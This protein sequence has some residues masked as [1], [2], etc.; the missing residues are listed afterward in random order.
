MTRRSL[1][2]TLLSSSWRGIEIPGWFR[3]RILPRNLACACKKAAAPEGRRPCVAASSEL[4]VHAQCV[5]RVLVEHL[6]HLF[7]GA[8]V[9]A[10]I[11]AR[12]VD[13]LGTH[14]PVI[15]QGVA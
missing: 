14:R 12:Q 8:A 4:V 11:L 2:A 10:H 13:G 3:E 7:D 15:A 9:P 1:C 5:T 6:D